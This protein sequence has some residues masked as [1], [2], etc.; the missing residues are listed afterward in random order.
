MDQ[1]DA[2]IFTETLF[3]EVNGVW[4]VLEEELVLHVIDWDQVVL[5]VLEDRLVPVSHRHNL[6]HLGPL[7]EVLVTGR[8]L[9]KG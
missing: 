7:N 3:D 2:I 4:E 6:R 9:T 5:D 8:L 1:D